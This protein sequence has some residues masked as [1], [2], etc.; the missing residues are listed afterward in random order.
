MTA[1]AVLEAT[2]IG[3]RCESRAVLET[4][5]FTLEAGEAVSILGPITRAAPSR[6]R[7]RA[8]SLG[9]LWKRMLPSVLIS[10]TSRACRVLKAAPGSMRRSTE[11]DWR[12]RG[13]IFRITARSPCP[14]DRHF[15]PAC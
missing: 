12:T 13:G 8:F 1:Q 3:L 11:W 14:A 15:R 10:N 9:S 7:I 4:F 5:D 2:K 6:F